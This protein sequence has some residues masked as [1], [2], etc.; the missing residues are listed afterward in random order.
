MDSRV[1]LY[2]LAINFSILKLF[3]KQYNPS[4]IEVTAVVPFLLNPSIAQVVS[5]F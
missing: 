3:E 5:A 2:G 4:M 1:S